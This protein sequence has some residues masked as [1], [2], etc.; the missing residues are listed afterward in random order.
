[1]ILIMK[2]GHLH[3]QLIDFGWAEMAKDGK[4]TIE[5]NCP[6]GTPLYIAPEQI[7]GN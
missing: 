6:H 4:E 3:Y 5:I 1:M 7:E 2:D